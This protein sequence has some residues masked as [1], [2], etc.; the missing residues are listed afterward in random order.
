M[1]R[2]L[3]KNTCKWTKIDLTVTKN[4]LTMTKNELTR[5]KN[6]ITT[7]KNEL[8]RTK[9]EITMTKMYLIVT[10]IEWPF[11][12]YYCLFFSIS[13]GFRIVIVQSS[14]FCVHHSIVFLFFSIIQ[15]SFS[16]ITTYFMRIGDGNGRF[17]GGVYQ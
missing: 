8:T 4:D 16:L 17:F 1:K 6:E 10:K 12:P 7:T 14:S 2:S 13:I 9:N 11:R 15:F 3:W 5:T